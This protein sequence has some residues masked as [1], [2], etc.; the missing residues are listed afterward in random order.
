MDDVGSMVEAAD[1]FNVKSD[2]EHQ[3]PGWNG[4][5]EILVDARDEEDFSEFL[6]HLF[7]QTSI[8]NNKD[9]APPWW[10]SYW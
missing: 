5:K 1:A 7:L 2:S 4:S 3:V 10:V 8:D 6:T 9:S